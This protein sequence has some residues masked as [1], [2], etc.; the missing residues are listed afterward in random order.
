MI[1][2]LEGFPLNRGRFAFQYNMYDH[3]RLPA[4][5]LID[6]NK[7]LKLKSLTKE[8]VRLTP[9]L[10]KSWPNSHFAG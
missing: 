1:F 6:L 5:L 4:V 8:D 10:H 9:A 2:A 3:A 7:F